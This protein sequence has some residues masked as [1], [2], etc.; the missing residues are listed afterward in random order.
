MTQTE[1]LRRLIWTKPNQILPQRVIELSLEPGVLSSNST[2]VW[3]RSATRLRSTQLNAA[4]LTN[5]EAMS[6][7]PLGPSMEIIEKTVKCSE[8]MMPVASS[9]GKTVHPNER[10]NHLAHNLFCTI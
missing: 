1:Q 9:T 8:T 3:L 10:T 4:M 2:L 5:L 6:Q 7:I